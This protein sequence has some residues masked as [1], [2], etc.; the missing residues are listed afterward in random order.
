MKAIQALLIAGAL[1]LAV[2]FNAQ[3][4]E[5]RATNKAGGEIRLTVVECKN[6]Q[7]MY[8]VYTYGKTGASSYG[9]WLLNNDMVHVFWADGGTSIFP[10]GSFQEV[11]NTT[12][13]RG[14]QI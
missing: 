13:P 5:F 7:N 14:N 9:C 6:K 10:A 8:I 2:A 1:L 4:T 3:A 11:V 12:Q